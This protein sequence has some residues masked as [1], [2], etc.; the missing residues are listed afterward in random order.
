M[1]NKGE[2]RR[3]IA[4]KEREKASK[5]AQLTDLKEDLRRLKDASKKLDTAGEDFNKGQSKLVLQIGKE[6]E[7]LKVTAKRKMSILN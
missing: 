2:I 3:Q 6:K 7:G 1:S 5:E 4:N